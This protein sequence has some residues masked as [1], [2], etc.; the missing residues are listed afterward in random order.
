MYFI[1]TVY[2]DSSKQVLNIMVI[3]CPIFDDLLTTS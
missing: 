1:V 2:I 3:I